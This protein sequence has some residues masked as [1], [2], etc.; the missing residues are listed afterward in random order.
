MYSLCSAVGINENEPYDD[1]CWCVCRSWSWV[2]CCG[3]VRVDKY[4]NKQ[5]TIY[6]SVLFSSVYFI[7]P[8]AHMCTQPIPPLPTRCMTRQ[9][10]H[11]RPVEGVIPTYSSQFKS[12]WVNSISKTSQEVRAV[13]KRKIEIISIYTDRLIEINMQDDTIFIIYSE[14]YANMQINIFRFDSL[15]LVAGPA[16]MRTVCTVECLLREQCSN[17]NVLDEWPIVW[18]WRTGW[19]KGRESQIAF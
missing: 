9:R 13:G 18:D 5:C 8:H 19:L 4:V 10:L 7:S 6:S 3:G 2:K 15:F 17:R 1:D 14:W 12:W 16:L 11:S